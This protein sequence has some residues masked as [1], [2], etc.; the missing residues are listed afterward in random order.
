MTITPEIQEMIDKAKAEAYAEKDTEYAGVIAK[1]DELLT[2]LRK[3]SA[4]IDEIAAAKEAA[5]MA[6]AEKTGNIEDIKKQ[7]SEKFQKDIGAKEA[8]IKEL[9][10]KVHKFAFEDRLT[11]KLVEVGVD[12][13][14]LPIVK[15]FIK[16][17]NEVTIDDDLSVKIGDDSLDDYVL[18]WSQS[19]TARRFLAAP[20][21]TGGGAK[22]QNGS[23]KAATSKINRADYDALS[24]MERQKFIKSGGEVVNS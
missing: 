22:G 2:K 9:K 12:K 19:E 10:G 16:S 5:E 1:K 7:L 4:T 17:E 20:V 24:P 8:E 3:T 18:K 11:G 23:G 21:N 15:A 6:L 13:D 14:A